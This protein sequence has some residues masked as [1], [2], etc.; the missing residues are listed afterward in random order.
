[1]KLRF[2]AGVLAALA[3]AAFVIGGYININQPVRIGGYILATFGLTI[4]GKRLY[5]RIKERMEIKR[6]VLK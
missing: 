4:M 3:G 5:A 6:T 2:N 1:M